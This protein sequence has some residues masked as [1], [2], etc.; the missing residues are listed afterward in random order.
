M[1]P[2]EAADRRDVALV[3]EPAPAQVGRWP[4]EKPFPAT[5][6]DVDLMA[7]IDR[8]HTAFY[9]M[10]ATGAF[11][12]L[13]LKPQLPVGGTLYSGRLVERWTRG[14]LEQPRYFAGARALRL[15]SA[16]SPR[17]GPGRPRKRAV[18]EE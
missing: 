5:L 13:E 12:F 10:K 9:R 15:S 11:K 2:V 7:V 16:E 4:L 1:S 14:E 18:G 6:H 3:E 8:G 17:R